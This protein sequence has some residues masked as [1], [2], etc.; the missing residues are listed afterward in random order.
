MTAIIKTDQLK[1]IVWLQTA[2]LGDMILSTGAFNLAKKEAP[3]LNQYLLTSPIGKAALEGHLALNGIFAIEKRKANFFIQA[4]KLK[5][6]LKKQGLT[7]GNCILIQLHRSSR[8]SIIARLIGFP[9]LSYEETSLSLF[10]SWRVKRVAVF[11][12]CIRNALP[13]EQLGISRKKILAAHPSLNAREHSPISKG[14]KQGTFKVGI[15]PGS[16][17]QTKKWPIEKF[18]ALIALLMKHYGVQLLLLGSGNELPLVDTLKQGHKSEF[19]E[20][21]IIDLIGKTKLEDLQFVYPQLNL[22]ISNDSSPIHYAS[23]FNIPTVAIF[24]ATVSAMGFG[25]LAAGSQVIEKKELS[26]RPCSA[27]GPN[28]CPLKHFKCMEDISAKEVYGQI[29]EYLPQEEQ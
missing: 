29:L 21:K 1:A 20:G 8:S 28:K 18:Q 9:I 19:E 27:H 3:H 13:L 17:W 12:E 16:V 11:H 24:G 6:S 15:A 5:Q 7:P 2:F 25:P 10:S 22:L 26:C 14:F 23:A 4:W